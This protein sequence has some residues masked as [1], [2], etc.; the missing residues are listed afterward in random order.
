MLE[1][2]FCFKIKKMITA[3]RLTMVDTKLVRDRDINFLGHVVSWNRSDAL[4]FSK[5]S[6]AKMISI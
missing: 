3:D 6:S 5:N 2:F 4:H 1:L